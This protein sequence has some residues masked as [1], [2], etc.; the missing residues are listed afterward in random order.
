MLRKEGLFEK[1]EKIDYYEN[2]IKEILRK[3]EQRAGSRNESLNSKSPYLKKLENLT[4]DETK[5][6]NELYVG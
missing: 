4:Q 5:L 6:L 3:A 2:G 1:L